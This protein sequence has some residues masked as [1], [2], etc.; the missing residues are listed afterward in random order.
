MNRRLLIAVFGLEIASG[1]PYAVA[2]DLVPVWQRVSGAGLLAVGSLSLLTVPWT[3]KPLWAPLVD[4]FGSFR[5]WAFAALLMAAATS[6]VIPLVGPWAFVAVVA[7]A[8][9]GGTVDDAADGWIVAAVPESLRARSAGIRVAGYRGALVLAGGGLIVVGDQVGWEQAFAVAS[10]ALVL[11][12]IAVGFGLGS[13]AAPPKAPSAIGSWLRRPETY[14]ALLFAVTYKIGD[15]AMTPMVRPFWLDAG[16]TPTEIGALSAGAGSFVTAV[17]AVVGGEWASRVGIRTALL[18]LGGLQIASNLVY[19][20]VATSPERWAVLGAGFFESFTSGLGTAP[21]VAFLMRV[22][23]GADTA[24]RFAL[25]TGAVG[26]TRNIVGPIAGFAVESTSYA[27][28]FLVT[29]VVAI[30]GWWLA[31]RIDT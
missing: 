9:A 27:T 17:G 15:T 29:A 22:T 14:A 3:L 16:L 30:P 23:A 20:A 12:A 28:W 24:T 1:V 10:A 2:T 5:A 7:L 6:L 25:M 8:F 26:L 18:Q 13:V 19:A 31:R 4:R 11:L 21:F